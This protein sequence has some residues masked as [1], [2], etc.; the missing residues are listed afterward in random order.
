MCGDFK[1]SVNPVLLAEQYPLPRTEDIFAN[2]AG[3]KRFSKLDLRQ[4]YHQMEV[5]EESKKFL[6][7]NTWPLPIQSLSFLAFLRVQR[8]GKVP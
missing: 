6:T 7:I 5:T 4:A 1:V 3:V 8:F 2:L